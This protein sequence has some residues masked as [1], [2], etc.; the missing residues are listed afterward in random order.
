VPFSAIITEPP[1]CSRFDQI[2]KPQADIAWRVKDLETLTCKGDISTKSLSSGLTVPFR[3][4][5]RKSIR[6]INGGLYQV[7]KT[8]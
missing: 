6:V 3:R 4:G 8:F 1:S 5:G 2:Q 7:I